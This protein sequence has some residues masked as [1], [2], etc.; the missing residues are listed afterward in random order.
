MS[1]G[2]GQ[3]RVY[4]IYFDKVKANSF[5]ICVHFCKICSLAD[6]ALR[7]VFS[8]RRHQERR[9]IL[10]PI[11]TDFSVRV[12]AAPAIIFSRNVSPDCGQAEVSINS[13]LKC[14]NIPKALVRGIDTFPFCL[15]K[16]TSLWPWLW[17]ARVRPDIS[18]LRIQDE[19]RHWWYQMSWVLTFLP[20]IVQ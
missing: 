10:T 17:P 6:L 16:P 15:I 5:W 13:C 7:L 14:F 1:V 8:I 19:R 3:N 18:T 12:T 20:L 9:A 4:I 11:L 2:T